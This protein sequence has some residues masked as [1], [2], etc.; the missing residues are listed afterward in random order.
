MSTEPT[1]ERPAAEPPQLVIKSFGMRTVSEM[2]MA[3]Q[4]ACEVLQPELDNHASRCFVARRI[5]AWVGGGERTFGGMVAA[6]MAAVELL[7]C[8]HESV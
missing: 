3:L 6:G 7:R 2:E 8:R 4:K 5:L 1:V